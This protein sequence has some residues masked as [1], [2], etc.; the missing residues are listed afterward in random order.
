MK[1]AKVDT[2]DD[3]HVKLGEN[4]VIKVSMNVPSSRKKVDVRMLVVSSGPGGSGTFGDCVLIPYKNGTWFKT[5]NLVGSDVPK[6]QACNVTIDI[7][8]SALQRQLALANAL[9]TRKRGTMPHVRKVY[10]NQDATIVNNVN[11]LEGIDIDP[12]TIQAN[13]NYANYS[14]DQRFCL[15]I[16]R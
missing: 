6:V 13:M 11:P 12:E 10:L 3:L 9:S 4:T 14:S 2:V 16:F 5:C 8:S 7:N 15:R 1:I